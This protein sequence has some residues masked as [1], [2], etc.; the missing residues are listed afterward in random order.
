M[1]HVRSPW[2]ALRPVILAG[3]AAVSWLTLS[4]T[5]ASAD[6]LSDTSSVLGGVTSSVTSSVSSVT[7]KLTDPVP[8]AP[9]PV[10]AP[11]P[12]PSAGLLQP[13]IGQVSSVADNLV[14]SVPVVNQVV[15]T[16][17]VS[18][19]STPIVA[20]ADE[21]TAGLVE[22]IVPPVAE[23]VPVLEPVLEPVSDLVTGNTPL[24][25][26]LPA[27]TDVAVEE[28]LP[29]PDSAAAAADAAAGFGPSAADETTFQAPTEPVA[30]ATSAAEAPAAAMFLASTSTFDPAVSGTAGAGAEHPG[31]ADPSPAADPV[32]ATPG[33]LTGGN[34]QSSGASGSAAWLSSDNLEH[35][36][37]G[38]VDAR[39]TN[40]H[41]PAPV[42]FDPGSSPD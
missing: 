36:L 17:T 40:E 19:V 35:L 41:A 23:A 25:V 20:V 4:S 7:G 6:T 34:G 11:V 30:M 3:A 42:S 37:P 26:Q 1:A 14:A 21:T 18:A 31:T 27:L 9:P 24:E 16:G 33:S 39:E 15:P 28:P 22:V 32:P 12:A 13:V 29:A 5:A 10:T 2:R 8:D 38:A